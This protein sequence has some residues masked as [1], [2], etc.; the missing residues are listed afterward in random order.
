MQG[1]F[2][3]RAAAVLD[4]ENL[5]PRPIVQGRHLVALGLKPGPKF[6]PLLDQAF[7]AQL[8]GLFSD[9]ET[10]IAWLKTRLPDPPGD[11]R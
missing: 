9:E 4:F 7:E 1:A 10:G 6:K 3:V 5:A 2:F 11:L 8:D